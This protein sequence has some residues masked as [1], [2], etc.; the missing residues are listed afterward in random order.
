M[1]AQDDAAPRVLAK[2]VE[3]F[4]VLD[5][6]ILLVTAAPVASASPGFADD[7]LRGFAERLA[8]RIRSSTVLSAMCGEILYRRP[9]EWRS[10]IQDQMVPAALWY[11][12][13]QTIAALEDHLTTARIREQIR[14]NEELISTPGVAV[15]PLVKRLLRDPLRLHEVLMPALVTMLPT[16]DPFA[17]DDLLCSIDGRTLMI[18]I[19]GTRPASDLDFAR[20]FTN[21]IRELADRLNSAGLEVEV[22]GAYAI[23]QVSERSIRADMIVS[24]TASLVLLMLLFIVAYGSVAAFLFAVTP[25]GAGIM[26]AFG[27]SALHF[28]ELTPIVAVIGALLAGLAIDYSIHLLSH[29]ERERAAGSSAEQSVERALG[30]VGPAMTAAC[31][32]SVVGFLAIAQSSVPA[33]RHFA[34]LG[35]TG[36]VCTLVA[37]ITLLPA[38][39]RGFATTTPR[40]G[41]RLPLRRATG[42][43]LRSGLR[44]PRA[45]ILGTALVAGLLGL[46]GGASTDGPLRFE[47]DLTVMHPRPN[48]PL[49]LQHTI[50]ERFGLDPD[51]FLL[52]LEAADSREL[53]S[54]AHR[55]NRA[56]HGEIA[57]AAGIAG[58]LGPAALLPDPDIVERRTH[59][60]P[61]FDAE[62]IIADLNSALTD[63][64]FDP[65]A[66]KAYAQFLRAMF[67]PPAPPTW[68][69]LRQYPGLARLI[70]PSEAVES[71]RPP[72]AAL[73]YVYLDRPLTG[74]P[75]RDR[76]IEAIRNALDGIGGV[77]LTGISV[78][79]HDTEHRIRADLARLLLIAAVIVVLWLLFYFRSPLHA[80]LAILPAAFGLVCLAGVMA[81]AG[82]RLNMV[83]LVGLPILVGIGVDDG[84]FLTSLMRRRDDAYSRTPIVERLAASCHAVV[85]TTL[86]TLLTFGTLTLTSTPAIRSLGVILGVGMTASLAGTLFLLAPILR[87]RRSAADA[88]TEGVGQDTG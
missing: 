44:H 21:S 20:T 41:E 59:A 16:R 10:F 71:D 66:F 54:I 81:A 78:I 62:R 85:M 32:T 27:I 76:A 84:I 79:G 6:L 13:D 3:E 77:T 60:P 51:P 18:R 19:A 48:K 70:L 68:N 38:M 24:I 30:Q 63:S 67:R 61:A 75:D 11:V 53:L 14:R 12:D 49:E 23:A 31:M 2:A 36:L 86:T 74:R 45:T 35:A 46:V 17:P 25:V 82:I 80:A 69:T 83:N 57:S 56:L 5:D 8:D 58:T 39:L 40:F 29:F 43:L 72:T 33:L 15:Q 87:V 47:H 9:R 28:T 88:S 73:A 22:T 26:A 64:A 7:D 65:A 52:Y 34:I 1:L 42:G 37:A 4:G 55:V 50:A